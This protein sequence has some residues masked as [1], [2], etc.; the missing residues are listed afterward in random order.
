MIAFCHQTAVSRF[1]VESLVGF[2]NWV[3]TVDPIG[4]IKLKEVIQL[5][6]TLAKTFDRKDKRGR[7]VLFLMPPQLPELLQHWKS[8]P[9][10]ELRQACRPPASRLTLITDASNEGWGFHT[11]LGQLGQGTWGNRARQFHIN[12]LEFLAVLRALK[13]LDPP[14][15]WGTHLLLLC[16]NTTFEQCIRRNG[17]ARSFPLNSMTLR[18]KELLISRGWTMD[19][20]HMKGEMN[21][22][23]D[24]LS[25]S[26][27]ISTEWK[28]DREVL[29]MG[30]QEGVQPPR[31][32]PLCN[33]GESSAS[34]LHSPMPDGRSDG[35]RL[36]SSRLEPVEDGVYLSS[37]ST[38]F[39][40]FGQTRVLRG[41]SG[42]RNTRLASQTLV[43]ETEKTLSQVFSV[44]RTGSHSKGWR[45]PFLRAAL[46]DRE[47]SCLD[48]LRLVHGQQVSPGVLSYL[49]SYLRNSSSRQYKS[50]WKKFR[51][52]IM[53]KN[54]KDID[55]YVV[56]RFCVFL[57]EELDFNVGTIKSYLAALKQPLS[58]AFGIDFEDGKFKQLM[59][60]F[61]L[62][63]PGAR[64]VE[65][66][67]RLE[68][69]L[70]LLE[71][72]PFRSPFISSQNLLMKCMFL[73]GLA[74]GPR[75]SEFSSLLRGRRFITF[76]PRMKSVTIIPNA[77]YLL[78]NESP[79]FRRTPVKIQAFLKRD[80]SQ[81][82]L[83]PVLTLS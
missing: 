47:L 26:S 37:S 45:E 13:R 18:V 83:C 25:R 31:S 66:K 72:E 46:L 60:S 5:Q 32:R 29:P 68:P 12:R 58:L 7:E 57:F 75:V 62:K 53:D 19:V 1:Q 82:P 73:L 65:P 30:M 42:S 52:F 63:R 10:A 11:S 9:Q 16:D 28:L 22:L 67:W 15:H 14:P 33:N 80:G 17:S 48:F 59:K 34:G 69:V 79:K 50:V 49:L 6:R 36:S 51:S 8:L 4:R 55:F 44:H 64:Y 77:L 56:A 20:A 21:S 38:G 23:A 76:S 27:A 71:S 2:L 41:R 61:W 39:S 35:D 81:H 78:K 24:T 3:T 70:E 40:G 43:F 74:M 54:Y